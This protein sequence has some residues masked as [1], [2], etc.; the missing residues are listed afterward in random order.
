MQISHAERI[1]ALNSKPVSPIQPEDH[2]AE[3]LRKMAHCEY[4]RLL[5]QE[6]EIHH[7]RNIMSLHDLV[8]TTGRL[9]NVLTL[10]SPYIS[11]KAAQRFEKRLSKLT[12]RLETIR[13][14]DVMMRDL[15]VMG[16]GSTDRRTIS[17]LIAR[18]DAQRLVGKQ[19]LY[20][21][22]S[23]KKYREFL[24]RFQLML[25]QPLDDVL[26]NNK[27]DEPHRLEHVLPVLVME[28]LAQMRHLST[29]P[30]AF[31]SDDCIALYRQLDLLLDT[32]NGM[33]SEPNDAPLLFV[34]HA[35]KLHDTLYDVVQLTRRLA[36]VIHLP[37]I[38]LE[39]DQIGVMRVYR[40]DLRHR[41]ENMLADVPDAWRQF[42]TSGTYTALAITVMAGTQDIAL[43]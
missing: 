1:E 24:D 17:S 5:E 10:L 36:F 8:A 30:D 29:T 13:L 14:L 33:Y 15:L 3:A 16:E 34:E 25:T 18:L 4:I 28:H 12:R 9:Q 23:S 11:E 22:L 41:R 21:S 40:D 35:Q 39:N 6:I 38:N 31:T 19:K 2:I 42:D 7:E 37:R 32:L 26:E 43:Q 27:A 20:S